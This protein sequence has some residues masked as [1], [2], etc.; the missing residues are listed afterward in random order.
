MYKTNY[1]SDDENLIAALDELPLWSAPFGLKLLDKIVLRKNIKA[2]DLGCGM[3]FPLIELAARLGKSSRFYG[4]DNWKAALNRAA[5]KIHQQDIK[6]V[7]LVEG[8]A[9]DMPF[10][11]DYFDLVVSNNG[12]NNVEDMEKAIAECSRTMKRE[13]QLVCTMN[14]P[15]TMRTFYG[16]F[17]EVMNELGMDENIAA[18]R[19]HIMQKRKPPFI[20]KQFLENADFRVES[21]DEDSFKWS[22]IDADAFFSH[23]TVR[24]AFMPPW[25]EIIGNADEYEI[26]EKVKA[27]MN[28]NAAGGPI[29]LEIPFACFDCRKGE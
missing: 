25:L 26:F 11:D 17:T 20:V 12:L 16:A 19:D 28:D 23:F 27:K 6:N 13:G 29:K 9:L 14:L 8:S 2:L 7:E 24:Y 3:G 18:L 10:E 4:L 1:N 22:F 15:A 21:A 5:Q